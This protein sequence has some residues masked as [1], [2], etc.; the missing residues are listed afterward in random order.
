MDLSPDAWQTINAVGVAC[1]GTLSAV[2]IAKLNRNNRTTQ[3]VGGRVD[4]ATSAAEQARDLS[5]P[6]GN[7]FAA[8]TTGLLEVIRDDVR[9]IR[10]EQ[11]ADRRVIAEHLQDHS[12]AAM[13]RPPRQ[14]DSPD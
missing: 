11:A 5:A 14:T 6:T 8:R 13:L 10:A 4:D 12:R 9:A 1:V 7:G 3:D 2:T